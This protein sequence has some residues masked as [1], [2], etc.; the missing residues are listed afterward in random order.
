MSQETEAAPRT[1][2][3]TDLPREVAEHREAFGRLREAA[4]RR[5]VGQ[6]A[7]VEELLMAILAE[8]HCLI[9]GVPGLAKTLMVS[10]IADLLSLGFK[11]IQ[12]TPDL[13]PSDITGATII[14][15]EAGSERGHKFLKGPIFSNVILADEIN[16]T[17]AKT[18]AALMEAM[19]ER[20]V[21]AAGMRFELERP[22]FVLAT[23][24]PIEQEGTYP[25]PVSQTD[26]FMFNV[27]IDYP[28]HSEE[29]EILRLT[30]SSY[31]VRLG[32]LLDREAIL[33]A[34]AATRRVEIPERLVGYATRI[35]RRSRPADPSAPDF[36]KDLL[37]WGGGPRA[38]QA[39]LRGA[40]AHALLSGRAAVEPEDIHRV[41][42]PT[43][44]HRLILSYHAEAEGI[45][46]D[47]I[48]ERILLGMPEGLYRPE[49]PKMEK[50]AS[51]FSRLFG[52]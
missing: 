2:P 48:I 47:S 26:R 15:E 41:I 49:A 33:R 13:M 39:L 35:I 27:L 8:G 43:L 52:R 51:L 16:R 4:A 3:E 44:R 22:F 40:K 11:R 20:Q 1:G 38:I 9:I 32:A 6:R 25:L 31:Q 28:T 34:I 24:N 14:S 18:Q 37:A 50:K 42:G 30:T 23:E 21:T 12:F 19:E 7:V 36:V 46:P 45:R 10:T 17:P 5:I 29:F